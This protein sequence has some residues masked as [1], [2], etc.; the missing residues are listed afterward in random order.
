MN[1]EAKARQQ[2][3]ALLTAAGWAVQ[4]RAAMNLFTKQGVAKF[5]SR[6]ALA[7]EGPARLRRSRPCCRGR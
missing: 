3:D 2:I 7:G 1:P 4:D 6:C 5:K